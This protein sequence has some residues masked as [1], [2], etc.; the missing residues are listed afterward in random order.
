MFLLLLLNA[1]ETVCKLVTF[2]PVE[3]QPH[4]IFTIRNNVGS[5][6]VYK[7]FFYFLCLTV[8]FFSLFAL[9]NID[10]CPGNSYYERKYCFTCIGIEPHERQELYHLAS[11][12]VNPYFF[13]YIIFY[14]LQ[15]YDKCFNRL[16][17]RDI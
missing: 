14:M 16:N 13:I 10:H 6:P 8:N 9:N 11:M 7:L 17:K 2:V 12:R 1:K 3:V 4:R 5:V 15:E